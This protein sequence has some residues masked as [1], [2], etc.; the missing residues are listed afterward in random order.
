[1]LRNAKK[2][3]AGAATAVALSVGVAAPS[4]AATLTPAPIDLTTSAQTSVNGA[5]GLFGAATD[6][7]N[8]LWPVAIGLIALVFL[9]FWVLRRGKKAAS[10][11]K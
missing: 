11:A 7:F 5:T 8:A 1:M 4:F 10:S 9:S 2:W 6:S 3:I